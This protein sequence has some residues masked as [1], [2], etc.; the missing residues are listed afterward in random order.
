VARIRNPSAA[1]AKCSALVYPKACD[2][3]PTDPVSRQATAFRTIVIPAA[4]I[5]RA[6]WKREERFGPGKSAAPRS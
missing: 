4:A 1:L 2:R 6:A 5:E 3:K